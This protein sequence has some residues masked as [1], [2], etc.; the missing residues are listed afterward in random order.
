MP[1]KAKMISPTSTPQSSPA[2]AV[3]AKG[4]AKAKGPGKGLGQ[5][6]SAKGSGQGSVPAPAAP[7]A[8][9]VKDFKIH[10]PPGSEDGPPISKARRLGDPDLMEDVAASD[11]SGD[12]VPMEEPP[13]AS[14][15]EPFGSATP[16]AE[17]SPTGTATPPASA[18]A[19]VPID[20][21]QQMLAGMAALTT[22]VTT[23]NAKADMLLAKFSFLDSRID[24]QGRELLRLDSTIAAAASGLDSR[25]EQLKADVDSKLAAFAAAPPPAP[26]AA[27]SAADLADGARDPW[28]KLPGAARSPAAEAGPAAARTPAATSTPGPKAPSADFGRKVFALGFP[29]KLP[30]SAL[31]DWWDEEKAKMPSHLVAGA[32]FQGGH[33]KTFGLLFPSKD[34]AKLFTA[35]FSANAPALACMWASPREGEGSSKISFRPE[36]TIAERDR[37]RALSKAWSVISPVVGISPNWIQGSMKLV[38]DSK[39]GTIS[40]ATKKDMWELVVLKALPEGYAV[41]AHDANLAYFGVGPAVAEAIRSNTAAASDTAAAASPMR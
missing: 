37:G 31:R 2:A 6:S 14:A 3:A 16:V 1:P 40:V 32:V 15:A 4:T 27:T 34:A 22:A 20:P 38:T 12:E 30:S 24:M 25:F 8:P 39:Q 35:S 9:D 5:P 10:T 21:I 29:R 11:L 13:G 26:A 19:S 33:G 23:T 36:R 41:L 18:S 28:V 17:P 7:S